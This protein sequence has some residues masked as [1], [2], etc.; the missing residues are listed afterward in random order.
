MRIVI[1]RRNFGNIRETNVTSYEN[2]NQ[3]SLLLVLLCFS[4]YFQSNKFLS[5]NE[6]LISNSFSSF[7]KIFME[8][9]IPMYNQ[10]IF[11]F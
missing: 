2:Y 3:T 9:T 7:A 11:L 6:D 4:L 1:K 5:L 8:I 10:L